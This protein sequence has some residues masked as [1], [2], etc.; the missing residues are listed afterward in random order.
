MFGFED[1]LHSEFTDTT[2]KVMFLSIVFIFGICIGS[3]R[4]SG[5]AVLPTDS[6]SC[7]TTISATDMLST[8]KLLRSC[9]QSSTSTSRG[10]DTAESQST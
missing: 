2:F 7:R 4:D 8:K 6:G 3:R 1:M 9:R 5:S 10:G